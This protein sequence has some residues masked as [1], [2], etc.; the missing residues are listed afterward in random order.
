MPELP[1]ETFGVNYVGLLKQPTY[2]VCIDST[3]LTQHADVIYDTAKNAKKAFLNHMYEDCVL[4]NTAKLYALPNYV[5]VDND[6]DAFK[7]CHFM[8]GYTAVYVALKMAY[9]EGYERVYLY[10]VDHSQEWYHF[11]D[12]YPPGIVTTEIRRDVMWWHYRYANEVYKKAGRVIY[13][14]SELSPLDKIFERA[15]LS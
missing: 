15:D 6:R 3:I 14:C 12:N 7:D 5:P 2:Y 13:N 4:D 8:S 1:Y 10:G 11:T 9:Y